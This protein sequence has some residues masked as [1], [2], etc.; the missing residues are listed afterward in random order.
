[1]LA[2]LRDRGMKGSLEGPMRR[3]GRKKAQ[4][5]CIRLWLEGFEGQMVDSAKWPNDSESDIADAKE[6]GRGN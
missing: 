5:Q 2:L 6:L 4:V 3:R 1:M